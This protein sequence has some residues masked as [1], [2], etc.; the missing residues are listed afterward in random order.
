MPYGPRSLALKDAGF[1]TAAFAMPANTAGRAL[2]DYAAVLARFEPDRRRTT[3]AAA[4]AKTAMAAMAV[5]FV[6]YKMTA[7]FITHLRADF[8]AISKAN[9]ARREDNLESVENTAA[10]NRLLGEGNAKVVHPDAIMHNK[11]TRN[12]DKLRAVHVQRAP[13]RQT[14]KKV[15]DIPNATEQPK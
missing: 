3:P 8:D 6:A 10:I 4:A 13:P 5:S 2:L 11:Y 14:A 15:G 1:P 9:E 7:D 12:S